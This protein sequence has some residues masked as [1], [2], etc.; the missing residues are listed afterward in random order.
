MLYCQGID[1]IRQFIVVKFRSQCKG[2]QNLNLYIVWQ[3]KL[4]ITNILFIKLNQLSIF[5]V[6][7]LWL[8]LFP[9]WLWVE[10]GTSKCGGGHVIMYL[11]GGRASKESC[12]L[13]LFLAQAF[14]NL[15]GI[16][17]LTPIQNY[18]KAKHLIDLNVIQIWIY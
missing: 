16:R 5:S 3:Y 17:I 14:L 2:G 6:F 4:C 7:F 8:E 11:D 1:T 15:L 9:T 10:R 18:L 13:C 12:S